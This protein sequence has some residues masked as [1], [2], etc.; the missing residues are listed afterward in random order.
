[1]AHAYS[2]IDLNVSQRVYDWIATMD[3]NMLYLPITGWTVSMCDSNINAVTISDHCIHVPK[4][5]IDKNI[6]EKNIAIRDLD[7]TGSQ[8]AIQYIG[9]ISAIF[10]EIN[11]MYEMHENSSS[12]IVKLRKENTELRAT[13]TAIQETIDQIKSIRNCLGLIKL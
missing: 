9:K 7:H 5:F 2:H 13:I 4:S 12:D 11:L 1:M 6:S 10:R 8:Y 3:R